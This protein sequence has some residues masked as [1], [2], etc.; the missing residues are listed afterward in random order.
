MLPEQI[1]LV[2]DSFARLAPDGDAVASAFYERLF[3]LDPALR[4]LFAGDLAEQGRKLMAMLAL[5]VRG[6]DR[7]DA[8]LPA[9][10]ALGRRHAAYGVRDADYATVGAAL[11]A[12]LEAG[13][14]ADFTPA[15]RDAW[16]AAYDALAGAMRAAARPAA[17]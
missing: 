5:V 12:T 10:E 16:T 6:L 3:A 2:R 7:L 15:T 13:L 8:L 17:A 4:P 14:G 1:A 9:V 11:L